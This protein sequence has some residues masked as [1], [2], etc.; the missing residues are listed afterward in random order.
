MRLRSHRQNLVVWS[1]SAG[2]AGRY[3]SKRFTPHARTRPIR[4]WT[5]TGALFAVIGLMRLA[6]AVR[7][8]R[9]AML[10]LAG[11]AL[12]GAGIVL[13]SGVTFICGMLVLLRGAAVTLG[14]SELHRRP[15]GAP[16]GGADFAGFRTPPYR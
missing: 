10:L 11:A 14:V 16:A 8:R 1:S 15:D 9:G 7:T 13:P 2:P 12:T 5:R 3:G 4:R 6:C